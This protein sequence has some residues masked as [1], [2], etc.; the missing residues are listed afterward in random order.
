MY[1][2]KELRAL[3]IPSVEDATL[4]QRQ[5]DDSMGLLRTVA[6][7]TVAVM[8]VYVDD[9]A[10]FGSRDMTERV[11]AAIVARWKTSTPIWPSEDQSVSFA[12]WRLQNPRRVGVLPRRGT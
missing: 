8:I 2:D 3:N 9:I 6:G 7:Q 5:T 12:E 10:V 11:S 1:R 4:M